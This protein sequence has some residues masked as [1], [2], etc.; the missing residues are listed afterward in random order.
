M[1][2]KSRSGRGEEP[3][4]PTVSGLERRVLERGGERSLAFVNHWPDEYSA[5]VHSTHISAAM[6]PH[7]LD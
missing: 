3:L 4:K 7:R 5:D 1:S 2:A 6:H